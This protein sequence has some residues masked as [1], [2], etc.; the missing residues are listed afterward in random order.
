MPIDRPHQRASA[1]PWPGHKTDV[2]FIQ[3]GGSAAR[4]NA[5]QAGS[6]D[7]TALISGV[8]HVARKS[9][10]V[11]LFDFADKDIEYQMTGVV[12]R[13]DYIKS[14]PDALRR[15]LRAYVEA[16]RYYKAN[17]AGSDQRNH[18][19]DPHRRSRFVGSRL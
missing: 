8:S 17:R 6:I 11:P 10:L 9:G 1:S 14:N 4:I 19:S 16:I 12:T 3:G 15:F 5:L 2:K 13:G 7:G 18:E